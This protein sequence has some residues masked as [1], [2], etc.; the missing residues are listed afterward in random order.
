MSKMG[1]LRP[2]ALSPMPCTLCGTLS[3]NFQVTV[4]PTLMVASAGAY[5][6]SPTSTVRL[7]GACCWVVVV[8]TG[9]GLRVVVVAAFPES[10]EQPAE[11]RAAATTNP[12]AN[13]VDAAR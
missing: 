6:M 11:N 2:I 5:F 8:V 10:P 12:A 3:E 13:R 7:V 1:L 4:S 9:R